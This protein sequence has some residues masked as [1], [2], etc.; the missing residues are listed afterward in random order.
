M[1][2]GNILTQQEAKLVCDSEILHLKSSALEK[3]FR[4]L[5]ETLNILRKETVMYSE[6][7]PTEVL[8]FTGKV[9][10][11]ENYQGLPYQVLDYPASF[12]LEDIFAYRTMFWWGN[13]YSCT[14]HLQGKYLYQYMPNIEN[15]FNWIQKSGLFLSCGKTPWRYEYEENNYKRAT[16]VPRESLRGRSFLKISKSFSLDELDN[17]KE[18]SFSTFKLLMNIIGL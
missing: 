16:E 1:N 14:L 8:E 7:L 12:S 17:L 6:A 11:G 9:S 5:S 3:I 2:T 13:F 18:N 15:N 4:E 10:R